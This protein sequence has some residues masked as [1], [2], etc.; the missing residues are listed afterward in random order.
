M[1]YYLRGIKLLKTRQRRSVLPIIG[2][3]LGVLFGMVSEDEVRLIKKKLTQ[4]EQKQQ[5]IAQVVKESISILN[6]TRLEL[7]EN[8]K[9]VNWI[10]AYLQDLKQ[11]LMNV[12]TTITNE[13]Q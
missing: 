9:S 5:S 4:V 13:Y 7:A 10:V 8:R 12:T 2:K 1:N 11:E 6:V 3:A